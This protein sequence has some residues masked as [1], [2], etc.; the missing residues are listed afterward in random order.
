MAG[1]APAPK[2]GIIAG[3]GAL[4]G[5]L[6]SACQSAGRPHFLLGLTGFAEDARLPRAADSWI[7]LGEVGK[8]F[9]TLRKAG[10]EEV[11]MAG[12]VKRPGFSELKP[13]LKGAAFL[14]RVAGRALGDDGLLTAVIAEIENEGF[15]VVGVDGI[16]SDLLAPEGP[17][18]RHQPDETARADIARGLVVAKAL[19]ATDVGQ[20]A[21]V[22]QGMV[23]GLEAAEGTDAMIAR[24]TPLRREGPGGVL[25]KV[26]KPQQER[27]ADLPTIGKT[28]VL[29]AAAAGLRGIAVEAGHTLIID[30]AA[31][32]AAADAAGLFVVGVQ[33]PRG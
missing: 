4:P 17:L 22:Q 10:V 1:A 24:C 18:G 28:T 2:L 11:V 9:D 25:V 5:L 33:A 26:K 15:R 32:A 14:A 3:G 30:R 20:A 16:L 23:L 6:V 19:G 21:V 8:G 27:R 7:R 13:D 29:N 31:V 12:A